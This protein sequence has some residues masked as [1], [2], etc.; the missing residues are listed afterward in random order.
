MGQGGKEKKWNHAM[1]SKNVVLGAAIVSVFAFA[2]AANAQDVATGTLAV[3]GTIVSSISLTIASAGGSGQT[4]MGRYTATTD[5]CDVSMLGAI[6][7]NFTR[8]QNASD[9]KI[10][11]TVGVTVTKANSASTAYTLNAKLASAPTAGI[12]WSV[13]SFA[14]NAATVVPLTAAGVWG[15]TP[16]YAWD[17]AILDSVP[18]TTALDNTIMFDAISG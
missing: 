17:I 16:V 11:S 8:V 3:S 10:S 7:T 15:S 2:G 4:G 13:N 6:P 14:L 5:L 9:Y 1:T 18:S 12:V